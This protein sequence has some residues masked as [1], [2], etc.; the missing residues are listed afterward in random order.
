MFDIKPKP[1]EK[2]D[3]TNYIYIQDNVLTSDQC[4][5]IIN[6][7]LDNVKTNMSNVWKNKFKSCLLPIDHDIKFIINNAW[8]NAVNYFNASIDF[9]EQYEVK[10]YEQNCFFSNHFDNMKNPKD[11]MIDRKLT[12]SI[13]LSDPTD[14]RG[15]TLEVANNIIPKTKGT[16][17][18]F[19]SMLIHRVNPV[20][21]GSRWAL[22]TWAW[23]PT[24][25]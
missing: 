5:D 18:V 20:L 22:I 12:C 11:T 10:C 24:F 17:V 19:P 7:G 23:G 1:P 3:W 2:T 15:G 21:S 8:E 4:N 16:M 25:R 9:I 14:Y 6:I 13:Q